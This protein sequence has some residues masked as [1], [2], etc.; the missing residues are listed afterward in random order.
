MREQKK[1]NV[2]KRYKSYHMFPHL[3]LHPHIIE[4]K[5]NEVSHITPLPR[6]PFC[7][8]IYAA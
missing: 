5:K 1:K 4:K 2:K 6:Q 8:V 7:Y 3:I